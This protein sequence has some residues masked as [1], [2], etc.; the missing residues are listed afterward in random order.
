MVSRCNIKLFLNR[1]IV[2]AVNLRHFAD[3]MC[4]VSM[5]QSSQFKMI[6]GL[7][8]IGGIASTTIAFA[9]NVL[10]LTS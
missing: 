6:L 8:I 5:L 1:C 2:I 10:H 3:K 9:H 7:N 4:N